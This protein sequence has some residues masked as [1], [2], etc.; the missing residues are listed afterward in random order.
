MKR[1]LTKD[2]KK[3]GD[4]KRTSE[5]NVQ[6]DP[7]Q[8]AEEAAKRRDER[9]RRRREAIE[10][11]ASAT[12]GE[13]AP[14]EQK[15]EATE[16]EKPMVVSKEKSVKRKPARKKKQTENKWKSSWKDKTQPMYALNTEVRASGQAGA[17]M[18]LFMLEEAKKGDRVAVY[19]GELIDKEE[20]DKRD[21]EY[22]MQIK[23]DVFLDAKDVLG[24]KGRFICHA[25]PG[26]TS[27]AKISAI[28]RVITDPKTKKPCV[29]ILA[30]KTIAPGAEILISYNK[31]WKWPWQQKGKAAPQMS[32][33][34]LH[35]VTSE[36]GRR[37]KARLYSRGGRG[38]GGRGRRARGGRG[39]GGR[40]YRPRRRSKCDLS[41]GML[42][43]IVEAAAELGH[44][45]RSNLAG[46]WNSSI[47]Y[48]QVQNIAK[49]YEKL[50]AIYE[51]L[52]PDTRDQESVVAD[53]STE[54]GSQEQVV[55][56]EH[57]KRDDKNKY[58][59]GR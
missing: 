15:V 16:D 31:A 47:R 37:N 2:Q 55:A 23:E 43:N 58:E 20:A 5:K 11:G 36:K 34:M 51:L 42:Q 39:R 4:S 54:D 29:S 27:N 59:R 1:K 17:G 48:A 25:G 14:V 13:A 33:I 56:T 45:A 6:P 40:S 7:K 57:K 3:A 49:L 19:A 28:R 38:R 50:G 26:T 8:K 41:T 30:R 52:K 21:S 24:R 32:S 53:E 46:L 12:I 18:G 22:I 10:A 44:R 9:A 35:R